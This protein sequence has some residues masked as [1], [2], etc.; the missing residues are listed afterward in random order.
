MGKHTTVS[1]YDRKAVPFQDYLDQ[2]FSNLEK[3]GGA[4][5]E[6]PPLSANISHSRK[7]TIIDAYI[8]MNNHV[9][10]KVYIWSVMEI[11]CEC[12]RLKK[13]INNHLYGEDIRLVPMKDFLI[14]FHGESFLGDTL[15]VMTWD[16]EEEPGIIHAHIYKN[17][18][19]LAH[20]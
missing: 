13:Y 17:G 5:Y 18:K 19:L 9:N 14:L 10:Y 4:K 11:V 15:D 2:S 20:S 7:K 1:I 8:D 3:R 6:T 16:K 12:F